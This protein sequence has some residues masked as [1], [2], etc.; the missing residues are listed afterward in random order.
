[1]LARFARSGSKVTPPLKNPDEYIATTAVTATHG[2]YTFVHEQR[3]LF[4]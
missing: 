3:L 1:M 4:D 2:L